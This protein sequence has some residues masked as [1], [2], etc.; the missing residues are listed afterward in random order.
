MNRGDGKEHLLVRSGI[1]PETV[2]QALG[3]RNLEP[4]RRR[5]SEILSARQPL[6]LMEQL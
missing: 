4:L 1:I 5:I 6:R 3:D 2:A